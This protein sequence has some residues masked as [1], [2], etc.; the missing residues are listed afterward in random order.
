MSTTV[1]LSVS[2][3]NSIAQDDSQLMS[4]N[5]FSFDSVEHLA[6]HAMLDLLTSYHQLQHLVHCVLGIF[7]QHKHTT[8][9]HVNQT[10]TTIK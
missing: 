8:V 10:A 1:E 4:A 9:T 5:D 6:L 3:I 7:L 2:V